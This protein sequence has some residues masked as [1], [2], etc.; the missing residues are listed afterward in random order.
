MMFT[1]SDS[2]IALWKKEQMLYSLFY[3]SCFS[4]QFCLDSKLCSEG[5]SKKHEILFEKKV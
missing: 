3:F 1:V 4:A 5:F 2:K